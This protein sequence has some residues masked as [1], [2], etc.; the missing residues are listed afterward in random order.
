[1][2]PQPRQDASSVT[3][4]LP[5]T[6]SYTYDAN[7]NLLS[8]GTRN[9]AYDDENQLTAVWVA[10]TWSSSFVYDGLLRKRVEKDYSWTG[11]AWQETNE[12]HFIYDGYLVVQERDANNLPRV[13]YTRGDDLSASLQGAGGIG[14]LLAR[15]D[16]GLWAANESFASAYYFNDAQGNVVAMV[17][18]NG[19]VVAQYQYDPFGNTLSISGPLA[20]ANR[21]RFSSKEWND[22]AGLYCYSF[23][24]YDPNLQRW[25]NR[26]PRED[27]ASLLYLHQLWN[28]MGFAGTGT[29][30]SAGYLMLLGQLN[31]NLFEFAKNAPT[32]F[33]DPMGLVCWN[34]VLNGVTDIAGVGVGVALLAGAEVGSGGL[35]N[36]LAAGLGAGGVV[37]GTLNGPINIIGGLSDHPNPLPSN[38][39]AALGSLFGPSAEH[40]GAMAWNAAN[41][42]SDSG[43]I[44]AGEN[45]GLNSAQLGLDAS[46]TASDLFGGN[47]DGA[48]TLGNLN[49]IGFGTDINGGLGLPNPFPPPA[50]PLWPLQNIPM[51][52]CL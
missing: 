10:N 50:Q 31:P 25:L 11:S 38:P 13:T 28:A 34:E 24:F 35:I 33:V 47:G 16:M 4:N 19:A 21:Y 36:I 48:A 42:L 1:L 9:F 27:F 7:G 20:G 3:V 46:S 8:D 37:W 6:P 43:A 23:R 5:A 12:T 32:E 51:P 52:P 14:G 39:G 18:T 17:N 45:L 44:A 15:T 41:I 30:S 26:D 29:T 2:S 22:T 40:A 49:N